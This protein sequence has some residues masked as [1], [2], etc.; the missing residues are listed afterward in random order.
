MGGLFG[1]SFFVAIGLITATI[2]EALH[3]VASDLIDANQR[4]VASEADKDLLLREPV[5]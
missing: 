3:R 2:L 4:L 1:L 5:W